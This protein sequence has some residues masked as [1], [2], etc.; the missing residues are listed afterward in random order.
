MAHNIVSIKTDELSIKGPISG[1]CR[2]QNI[3]KFQNLYPH[4]SR[5]DLFT[6]Q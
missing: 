2:I 1:T 3:S 5:I 6:L 4:Q